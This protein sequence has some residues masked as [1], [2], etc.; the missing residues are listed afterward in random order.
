MMRPIKFS[1]NAIML[2]PIMSIGRPKKRNRAETLRQ[3]I[4]I[5][6]CPHLFFP[7][8]I[9]FC[10]SFSYATPLAFYWL[11]SRSQLRAIS[12][13]SKKFTLQSPFISPATIVSQTGWPK[14]DLLA[15]VVPP[16]API[17]IRPPFGNGSS[18]TGL[19]GFRA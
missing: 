18:P 2:V 6:D 19:L 16:K 12:R 10:L 11:S 3:A 4:K 17:L 5:G 15:S 7:S 13:K 8:F 9:W 14:Y 1:L